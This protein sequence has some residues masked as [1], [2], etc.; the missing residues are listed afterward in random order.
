[1]QIRLSDHFTY[2]RLLR[3]TLP[4]IVM[5]IFTS[6]YGVVDGLFFC[7][8]AF[9]REGDGIVVQPPVYGPF[10]RAVE[11]NG[12]RLIPSPLILSEDGW[13]M[14]FEGLEAAFSAGAKMMLLCAPHNPV[15]RV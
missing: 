13:R 7:V 10:Y 1:M 5:M 4:P 9:T 14:D 2:R 15:G 11:Q 8:N 3:F 6:I 12:R